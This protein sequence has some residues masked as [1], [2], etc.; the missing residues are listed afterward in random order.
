MV[1]MIE[2]PGYIRGGRTIF[3]ITTGFLI[4]FYI[5]YFIKNNVKGKILLPTPTFH[6]ETSGDR[7]G[8]PLGEAS[9]PTL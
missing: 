1:G 8:E 7:L 5:L 6:D 9:W 4:L 3:L 2:I